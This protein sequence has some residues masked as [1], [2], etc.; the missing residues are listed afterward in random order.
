MRRSL[1]LQNSANAQHFWQKNQERI[2]LPSTTSD[3]QCVW[4]KCKFVCKP[5]G[6]KRWCQEHF[7]VKYLLT[8]SFERRFQPLSVA[9]CFSNQQ[10]STS[11]CLKRQFPSRT[12]NC[13]ITRTSPHVSAHVCT[14]SRQ[15]LSVQAE[16]RYWQIERNDFDPTPLSMQSMWV[17]ITI[18]VGC[19]LRGSTL[20]FIFFLF[21][22]NAIFNVGI[23]TFKFATE[24]EDFWKYKAYTIKGEIFV[25][26]FNFVAFVRLK[27]VRN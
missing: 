18:Q 26:K 1:D 2:A 27:K 5:H 11:W 10:E 19:L 17:W 21:S 20:N 9:G 15:A 16:S 22:R 12:Q 3:R 7:R 23:Q 8:H 24:T 6:V 14:Y 4:V 13:Q 25:Q